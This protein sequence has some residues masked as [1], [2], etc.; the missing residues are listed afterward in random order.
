MIPDII[1]FINRLE[2]YGT[3]WKELHWSAPSMSHHKLCD[4]IRDILS[5]YEDAI[6]E[7]SQGMYGDIQVGEIHPVLPASTEAI[8]LLKEIRAD[9]ANMKNKWSSQMYTGLVNE[10]DDLFHELNKYIYLFNKVHSSDD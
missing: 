8:S 10:S 7:D 9:V 4:E 6:A 5:D 3:R 1:N 2:G